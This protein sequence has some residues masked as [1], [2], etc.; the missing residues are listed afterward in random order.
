MYYLCL[1]LQINM[2]VL[3]CSDPAPPP[4]PPLSDFFSMAPLIRV[5]I[6]G[7]PPIHEKIQ[8]LF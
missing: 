8:M 5:H 7:M 4:P 1:R 6:F 3:F 2:S